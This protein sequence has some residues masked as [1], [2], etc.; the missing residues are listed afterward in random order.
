MQDSKFFRRKKWAVV[1]LVNS[2]TGNLLLLNK[3][4]ILHLVVDKGTIGCPLRTTGT[5]GIRFPVT[6][7]T[8]FTT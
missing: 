3:I 7:V 5:V 2:I 1:R 6:E 4:F 8:G